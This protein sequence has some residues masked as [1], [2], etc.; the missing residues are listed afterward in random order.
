MIIKKLEETE[1][2]EN[3][4]GVEA[5]KL[6]DAD[7]AV[8]IVI[9][10]EPGQHLKRHITATDV[11][12]YV[13]KG[14]GVVEVGDE[15]IEVSKDSLIESPKGILHCWYNKSDAPLQFMVI[16]SPKPTT[17]PIFVDDK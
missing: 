10:L 9:T 6:Y 7:N 11:A 3:S 13:L 16:K 5:K 14:V 15:K 1:L 4:H 12:F 17:G 2:M 8:I